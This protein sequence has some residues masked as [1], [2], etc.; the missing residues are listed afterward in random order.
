MVRGVCGYGFLIGFLFGVPRALQNHDSGT[1]TGSTV[2]AQEE[3]RPRLSP[4]TNLE[5]I[6][7]WLTKILVGATLVELTTIPDKVRTAAAYMAH[8]IGYCAPSCAE[9]D[10]QLAA[11]LIVY[12]SVVGFLAGYLLTRMFLSGAFRQADDRISL[13]LP[14]TEAARDELR[15][16][17]IRFE[18]P[19]PPTVLG[20]VAVTVQKIKDI[21]LE[22]VTN[23]PKDLE[24]WAKA[25]MDVGAYDK[26][27]KGYEKA[28]QLLPG[29]PMLRYGYAIALKFAGRP[30]REYQAQLVAARDHIDLEPDGNNRRIIYESLTYNTLYLPE[31]DS[32]E[33]AIRY[34]NE[35]NSDP[36]NPPS[37][38][39]YVNLAC[40]YGQLARATAKKGGDTGAAVDDARNKALQSAQKALQLD[41]SFLARLQKLIEPSDRDVEQGE[42]DLTIF[43]NDQ[44]FR[45]LLKLRS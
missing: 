1:A 23:D 43:K 9:G 15:Q 35:Y 2:A 31:P 38:A 40:A 20:S 8:G 33:Q 18:D 26:A 3:R 29:K 6:S 4:N 12:F 30:P 37:A 24:A 19:E 22:Q 41:S 11:A 42:D 5:Q 25:Q 39:I 17:A 10:E 27:V 32:Y 14:I 45:R 7:D 21:P 36:K 13:R 34:G 44:D 16:H 28:L